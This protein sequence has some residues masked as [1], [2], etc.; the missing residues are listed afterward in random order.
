METMTRNERDRLEAMEEQQR[1]IKS[2][3]IRYEIHQTYYVD[4]WEQTRIEGPYETLRAA[5]THAKLEGGVWHIWKFR[6]G[7]GVRVSLGIIE[8][9]DFS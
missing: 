5:R 3:P 2:M 8:S 7:E 1:W 6:A 4:G 9:R